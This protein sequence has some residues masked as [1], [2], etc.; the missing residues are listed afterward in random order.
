MF[1]LFEPEI[2]FW[3][4]W[5]FA[6]F[7]ATRSIMV[8]RSLLKLLENNN[9]G[10]LEFLVEIP[11]RLLSV[12]S[13]VCHFFALLFITRLAFL[14]DFLKTHQ[15]FFFFSGAT[16]LLC[17][18][19]VSWDSSSPLFWQIPNGHS[20]SHLFGSFI[21]NLDISSILASKPTWIPS[22]KTRSIIFHA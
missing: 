20:L 18:A 13:S 14:F 9:C 19:P 6:K 21:L 3:F 15:M 10:G 7:Y 1:H 8:I 5:K 22:L 12:R 11:H 17:F 16:Q 4:P 2:S